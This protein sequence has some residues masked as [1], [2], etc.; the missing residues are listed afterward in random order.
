MWNSVQIAVVV[1]FFSAC[2]G[3]PTENG[4]QLRSEADGQSGV[5]LRE[6]QDIDSDGDGL[7]DFQETHKYFTDPK[8]A[9]TDGDGVPDGEWSERREYAYTIRNELEVLRP[10]DITAM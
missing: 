4:F 8:K 1:A 7:S 9:D 2:H 3:R 10:V 6:N 5:W